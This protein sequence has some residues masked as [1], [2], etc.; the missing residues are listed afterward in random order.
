MSF[1]KIKTN[2]A[3]N[4]AKLIAKLPIDF[5]LS[6]G[7]FMGYLTW[8]IPNKRK[9]IAATNI[10]LCFPEL[11]NQQQSVLLKQNIIS[12]GIGFMEM[13][14]AF[15]SSPNKFMHRCDIS[16]LAHLD[17]ALKKHKG[18]LLL[19][20]HLHP[21]ELTTKA[22][23]LSS[24]ITSH[25]LAR[26]HNN[27]IFEAH[28]DKARRLHCDKTIDKKDIKEVLK[29]L[30]DNHPIYYIPDQNFSY[31]FKFI[32][33][34]KQPAA[35]VIAPARLA[36]V[37]NTPVVPWFGFRDKDERGK[38]CWK[39]SILKPLDYFNNP[40]TEATLF[41][42]NALFEDQIRKHPEQYLWVHRRFKNHPKGRNFVYKDI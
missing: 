16:G 8:L 15:W 42:M 20:C 34:F 2:I 41:K 10:A 36:Q 35:T 1:K 17:E 18:C 28:V 30:K 3:V 4:I 21:I 24:S 27:K 12:T 32:D 26:Q 14:I 37:S 5:I 40:D 7:H 11:S 33:F 22:I 25:L 13:I 6:I 31:Q 38:I 29:S 9:K 39:I 19:S 23:N